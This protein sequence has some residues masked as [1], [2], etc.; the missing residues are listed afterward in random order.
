MNSVNSV[1][2]AYIRGVSIIGAAV[3]GFV[4]AKTTV[5]TFMHV[6][7]YSKLQ[8]LAITTLLLPPLSVAGA[9]IG[10][11]IIHPCMIIGSG[12]M[13]GTALSGGKVTFSNGAFTSENR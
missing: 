3:G 5:D 1:V 13:I 2:A 4:T 11:I 7:E 9:A 6:P 12:I 10:A 8:Q